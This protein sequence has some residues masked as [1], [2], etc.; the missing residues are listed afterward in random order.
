MKKES[1]DMQLST[2]IILNRILQTNSSPAYK[3][4]KQI[5]VKFKCDVS[6]VIRLEHFI[7]DKLKNK[8][9]VLKILLTMDI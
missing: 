8:I 5:A 3:T 4:R 7:I 6:K 2:A 1:K 9:A